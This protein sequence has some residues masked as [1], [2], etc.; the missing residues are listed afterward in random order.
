MNYLKKIFHIKI[1]SLIKHVIKNSINHLNITTYMNLSYKNQSK[2]ASNANNRPYDNLR[3]EYATFWKVL[4]LSRSF[5]VS[6][7]CLYTLYYIFV[8]AFSV[9]VFVPSCLCPF[10]C[11][12]VS[13][14]MWILIRDYWSNR[15]C[16]GSARHITPHTLP[17][18]STSCVYNTF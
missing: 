9:P 15:L 12:F 13:H 3:R 4:V 5:F 18:F 16:R 1:K 10:V 6:Q 7:R 2:P 11:E 14:V 17:S 8:P